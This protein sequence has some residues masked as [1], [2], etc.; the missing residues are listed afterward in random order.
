MLKMLKQGRAK[1]EIRYDWGFILLKMLKEGMA[2]VR[3]RSYLVQKA[4]N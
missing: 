4:K 3:L 2:K 1:A